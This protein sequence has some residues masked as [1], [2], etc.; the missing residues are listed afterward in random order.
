MDNPASRIDFSNEPTISRNKGTALIE[1][2][3]AID[4]KNIE[5]V[6]PK[7]EETIEKKGGE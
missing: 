1:P 2:A 7:V 4:L 5:T 6:L 3:S